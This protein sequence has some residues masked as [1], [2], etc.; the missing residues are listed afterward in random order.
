ME[1]LLLIVQGGGDKAAYQIGV[2]KTLMEKYTLYEPKEIIATSGGAANFIYYTAGQ[3][4]LAKNIWLDLTK[5]NK[6]IHIKN[7]F[8]KRPIMNLNYLLHIIKTRYPLDIKK[9]RNSKITTYISVTNAKTRKIEYFTNHQDVNPYH[10]LKASCALPFFWGHKVKINGK[11][12]IDGGILDPIGIQKA[13]ELKRKNVL[14]ILTCSLE[15]LEN[16]RFLSRME[17]KLFSYANGGIPYSKMKDYVE[18]L[19]RNSKNFYVI[20]PKKPLESP[21]CSDV[22][23][24][25]DE[26]IRGHKETMKDKRLEKFMRNIRKK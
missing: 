23:K 26:I 3:G 5:E 12:Y 8:S 7:L 6:F 14:L 4:Y 13:I 17:D 25:S 22:Q 18:E 15:E 24:I 10:L 21:L 20:Q 9:F 19:K 11:R 1:D 2:M 16:P